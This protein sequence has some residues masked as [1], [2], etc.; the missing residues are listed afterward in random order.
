MSWMMRQSS[1][2]SPGQS[3][4]LLILMMRPSTCVTVPFVL[5]VQ[6]ARQHDVRVPG[7]V[8][9][10]EVDRGVELQLLEAARD[11]GVVRQ[12][13]L[14]VEADREQPLDLAAIDLAEQLV[15]IDAGAGQLLL[16]DPPDAGD[17]APML[18]VA[19]VA[20]ARELIALLPVLAAA[21]PVGLADDRAVAAL[22]LADPA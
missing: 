12:R 9:E 1:R 18:R 7:R 20:P 3:T 6:A 15:G 5:L 2:A 16:V 21:L 13:D 4:A 14:R 8:V 19:D 22:R 11:E 10:E 17:V